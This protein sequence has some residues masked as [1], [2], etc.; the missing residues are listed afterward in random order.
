VQRLGCGL[1]LAAADANPKLRRPR[2]FRSPLNEARAVAD[3]VATAELDARAGRDPAD[4]LSDLVTSNETRTGMP[5]TAR[6]GVS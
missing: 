5:T 1:T 6:V 3:E 4:S 2:R